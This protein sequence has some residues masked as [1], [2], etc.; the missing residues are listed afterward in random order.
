MKKLLPFVLVLALSGLVQAQ[1]LDVSLT[2][3]NTQNSVY[4]PGTGEIPSGSLGAG[5]IYFPDSF[6]IASYLG[7]E[8]YALAAGYGI[9][10]Y[11]S[12]D[13]G[14]HTMSLRQS[15]QDSRV[16]LGFTTGDYNRVSRAMPSIE[17]GSFFR[18]IAPS[19]SFGTGYLNP[20]KILLS[21]DDINITGNLRI[22]S[23]YRKLTISNTGYADGKP[24]VE[25]TGT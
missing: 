9:S 16:L 18:E 14:T 1:T 8:L 17:D 3:N 2:I 13:A 15:L 19:F 20:I 23:G 21:Y 25:I 24:I 6:Y 4:I 5:T 10:L 11:A 7:N 12:N 22:S